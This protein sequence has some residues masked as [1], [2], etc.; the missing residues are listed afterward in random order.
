MSLLILSD[1]NT[2]VREASS[3]FHEAMNSKCGFNELLTT[4]NHHLTLVTADVSRMAT[5]VEQLSPS[6]MK[7]YRDMVT[8]GTVSAYIYVC[9]YVRRSCMY[10]LSRPVCIV[11]LVPRRFAISIVQLATVLDQLLCSPLVMRLPL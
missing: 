9:T 1:L 5:L 7:G 3:S 6:L 11:L 2:V 4:R 10:V 8:K